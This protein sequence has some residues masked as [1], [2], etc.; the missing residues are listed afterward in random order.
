[1]DNK[2]FMGH[3]NFTHFFGSETS[4]EFLSRIF[5]PFTL[6]SKKKKVL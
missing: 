4:N 6:F 3:T 1:M 5:L 2:I